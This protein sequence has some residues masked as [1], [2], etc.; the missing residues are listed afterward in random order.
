MRR[1]VAEAAI[2]E[3]DPAAV[4]LGDLLRDEDGPAFA[5]GFAEALLGS[6]SLSAAASGLQRVAPQVPDALPWYIRTAVRV[7]GGVA[8]ALP[9]PT[10]PIARRVLRQQLAQV[11]LDARPAKLGARIAGIRESGAELDLTLLGERVLGEAGAARRADGIHAL[12]RRPDVDHVTLAVADVLASTDP[13]SFD[14]VVDA[15]VQRLLPLYLSAAEDDTVLTLDVRQYRD[16]DLTIAVFTRILEDERLNRLRAGIVLP[17]CFPDAL[18]ALRELTA[19][20]LDR[21]QH[22]GGAIVVRLVRD[23]NLGRERVDAA[24][25]GWP[26]AVSSAADDIDAQLLR[27]LDE[28]LR[29]EHTDA[30]RV[31]L[32]GHDLFALAYARALAEERGAEL[33]VATPLGVAQAQLRRVTED[34]GTI[35]LCAP[36]VDP[37]ALDAAGEY[38]AGLVEA[39]TSPTNLLSAASRLA[40]DGLL[41]RE[42]ARFLGALALSDDRASTRPLRTQDRRAPV[43]ES[44][45]PATTAP[46]PETDLTNIVLGLSRGSADEPFLETAVYSRLESDPAD[47]GAPGFVNAPRTD[48]SLPGN[49]AWARELRGRIAAS[50]PAARDAGPQAG[51]PD[52]E[53]TIAAVRDAAGEWGSRPASERSD[54]LLRAAVA[55]EARRADLI[56]VLASE[57]G[58]TLADADAQVSDLVDFARFNG[59]KAREL[60]AVAGASFV[61]SRVTVV[62]SSTPGTNSGGD[63]LAALAAG[64]GVVL[65]PAPRAGRAAAVLVEALRQAGIPR[66]AL[67]IADA[68]D[69]AAEQELVAHPDVDRVLL[70]GTRADAVRL[71]SWRTELPLAAD[72]GGANA[73]I[74]TASADLDQAVADAVRSAFAQA[75]QGRS[76]VSL[77]ILVGPVGRSARFARQLVDATRSLAVGWPADAFVEVGPLAD[78][79]HEAWA[80]EELEGDEEWLV[81]PQRV[82]GDETGRLWTPGIRVGVLPGS[83]AHTE[84]A[85]APVLGVMHAPSL[86]RAIELQN[87]CSGPVAGLHAHDPDELALWLAGVEAGELFVNRPTVDGRVQR[88]PAGGSSRSSAAAGPKAG[89]PNRLIALGEWRATSRGAASST[90]HL[91]GLDARIT[92]LIEASQPSLDY[93][94]F[95]W[96]RRAALADAIAWDREFGQVR[97]ASHLEG[98][99]NLLRYRPV[100]VSIRAAA[101]AGAH[102][103]LRVVLAGLRAGSELFLS[104]ATGVPGGIRRR[105]GELGVPVAVEDDAEWVQRIAGGEER[106]GCV[107]IV[108]S[109]ASAPSLHRMLAAALDGDPDVVIRAGE[110]T[111][112]GR[113][114][115]LDF[116]REQSLSLTGHRFGRPDPWSAD[117]I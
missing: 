57:A 2:V 91:R 108:G 77:L 7:G 61:P 107:R 32:A 86:A 66:G 5:H 58:T 109:R 28:A 92:D 103:L 47:G 40:D 39:H 48:L 56:E 113:I 19:W 98:E 36:V 70:T 11:L 62:L 87:Q 14:E 69:E 76:A 27:M 4:L 37:T 22:S 43:H 34:V 73:I 64:S 26:Q 30:V 20:A 95:E 35:R 46:V 102:E 93:E 41:D 3:P 13:W 90:L 84:A 117:V 21:V 18:A 65:V 9:A 74:V 51:S 94:R 114:E 29:P 24:L 99:R 81:K 75:G 25:Q 79:P 17:A 33:E 1:W 63:V 10:V 72:T 111:S 82:S 16:L 38:V 67:L 54:T 52:V 15:A 6:H 60:D 12:I 112:A 85:A 78:R 49:R 31:A 55:L 59:A 8:Q 104:A 71:R 50:A 105:L 80:L 44:V 23:V 88:Q 53:R 100:P 68:A 110:V 115:L 89:G 101:D 45:R 83:R 116:V 42:Q 106:P 97:D 96:L